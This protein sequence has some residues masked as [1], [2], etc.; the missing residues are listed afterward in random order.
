MPAEIA[1]A[2]ISRQSTIAMIYMMI[3]SFAKFFA[4]G[5]LT[6]AYITIAPISGR[7]ETSRYQRNQCPIEVTGCSIYAG[8][9]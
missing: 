7:N 5:S 2:M 3:M 6:D 8:C 1:S 9:T 4:D